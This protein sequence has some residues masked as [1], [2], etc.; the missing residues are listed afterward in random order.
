MGHIL[1]VAYDPKNNAHEHHWYHCWVFDI[2]PMGRKSYLNF[3]FVDVDHENNYEAFIAITVAIG[4]FMLA[5][6]FLQLFFLK[7]SRQ[8][9]R[10]IKSPESGATYCI[11]TTCIIRCLQILLVLNFLTTILRL[12]F[13]SFN[14][15]FSE[16]I[17]YNEKAYWI[18]RIEK[19]ITFLI[20]SMTDLT[21]MM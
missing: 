9:I 4:V 20:F 14:N 12:V 11:L 16:W 8:L 15:H 6:M 7:K 18:F 2:I 1:N 17:F 21:Y 5:G 3:E 19:L 10:M 13:A